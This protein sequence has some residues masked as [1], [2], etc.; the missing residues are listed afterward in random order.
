MKTSGITTY[1]SL[2]YH[3]HVHQFAH[4]ALQN[5]HLLGHLRSIIAQ[6]NT[7]SFVS[8]GADES[9]G[10]VNGAACRKREVAR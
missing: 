4:F 7:P 10:E 3:S 8:L 5:G 1:R 9:D 2:G 6:R